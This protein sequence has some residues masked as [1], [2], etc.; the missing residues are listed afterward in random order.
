MSV[1]KYTFKMNGAYALKRGES[2]QG[3]SPDVVVSI[4]RPSWWADSTSRERRSIE[5]EALNSDAVQH[6]LGAGLH[7]YEVVRPRCECVVQQVE[8]RDP[9]YQ[10][11]NGCCRRC[12]GP[13]PRKG[14]R[15]NYD[16]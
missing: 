1:I 9:E 11:A 6:A 7:I 16:K 4:A 8:H 10:G 5:S 12:Y 14:K 13:L 2:T 15:R 3:R